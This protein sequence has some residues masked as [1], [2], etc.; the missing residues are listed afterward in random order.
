MKN[1]HP[2]YS[3]VRNQLLVR[4]VGDEVIIYDR[5]TQKAHCLTNIAASVW[6]LWGAQKSVH[7]IC[8]ALEQPDE[9]KIWA[10]LSELRS[11]GL[12]INPI[13]RTADDN[14]LSRRELVKKAGVGIALAAPFLTSIIVPPPASAASPPPTPRRSLRKN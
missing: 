3:L 5:N 6:Q 9:Q 1:G 10:I 13:T 11:A 4:K 8:V 14:R 2:E 12:L 7:E